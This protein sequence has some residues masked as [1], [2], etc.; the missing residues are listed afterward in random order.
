MFSLL[1]QSLLLLRMSHSII[2][3]GCSFASLSSTE[4]LYFPM[5]LSYSTPMWISALCPM[6]PRYRLYHLFLTFDV[7]TLFIVST[8]VSFISAVTV[9]TVRLFFHDGSSGYGFLR[10]Y[11]KRGIEICI[12]QMCVVPLWRQHW[13]APLQCFMVVR[14]ILSVFCRHQWIDHITDL[15]SKKRLLYHIQ[16][17]N[18]DTVITISHHVFVILVTSQIS[19]INIYI[20]ILWFT[21]SSFFVQ[22][23]NCMYEFGFLVILS[24]LVYYNQILFTF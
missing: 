13:H 11:F 8:I 9:I 5:F 16:L 15:C 10:T 22:F 23:S 17:A 4:S 14:V 3:M 7:S 20:Y 18:W 12:L 24:S 2:A 6:R 19:V 21:L 1:F